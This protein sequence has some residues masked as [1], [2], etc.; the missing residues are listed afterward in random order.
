MIKD[1]VIECVGTIPGMGMKDDKGDESDDDGD[2]TMATKLIA[3]AMH[4][5]PSMDTVCSPFSM[6]T[7]CKN[8]PML[9]KTLKMGEDEVPCGMMKAMMPK[10]TASKEVCESKMEGEE[11]TMKQNF[12]MVKGTCCSDGMSACDG[13][14]SGASSPSPASSNASS[15]ATSTTGTVASVKQTSFAVTLP[16]IP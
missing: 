16:S 8:G 5:C 9:D 1:G 15:N 10:F 11:E 3:F 2:A 14:D 13:L 7:M 4:C 6:D 12:D